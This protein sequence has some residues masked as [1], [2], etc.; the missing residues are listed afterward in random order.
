MRLYDILLEG[1]EDL[2]PLPFAE[3]RERLEAFV[4]RERPARMDLS[5]LVPAGDLAELERAARR[6]CAARRSRA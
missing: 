4:A 6:A 1:E 2:R 5:P 3:R